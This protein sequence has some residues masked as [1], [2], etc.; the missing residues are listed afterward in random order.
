MNPG[1]VWPA[2]QSR[3]QRFSLLKRQNPSGVLCTAGL[4]RPASGC[5]LAPESVLYRIGLQGPTRKRVPP[6]VAQRTKGGA[7]LGDENL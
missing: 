3:P 6:R 4:A 7:A 5:P 2:S 1:A